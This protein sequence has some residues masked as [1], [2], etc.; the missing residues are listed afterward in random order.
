MTTPKKPATPE[1]LDAELVEVCPHC[2]EQTKPI[3]DNKSG[4]WCC[5]RCL[6]ANPKKQTPKQLNP[7]NPPGGAGQFPA[8]KSANPYG[9]LGRGNY[10]ATQRF[11]LNIRKLIDDKVLPAIEAA[12][13]DDSDVSTS[14]KAA[15]G[16]KLM[17]FAYPKPK[18]GVK[19][20]DDDKTKAENTVLAMLVRMARKPEPPQEG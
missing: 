5:D 11:K 4:L 12:F 15:I 18:A 16:L 17:E 19:E 13:S 14:E 10:D 20:Q 8:G 9:P 1:V 7:P 2:K 3:L 6:Y